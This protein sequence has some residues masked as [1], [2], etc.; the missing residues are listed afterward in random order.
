MKKILTTIFVSKSD[1]QEN[2]YKYSK[3][4]DYGAMSF[5]KRQLQNFESHSYIRYISKKF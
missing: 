4:E 5:S 3:I 1:K 2:V